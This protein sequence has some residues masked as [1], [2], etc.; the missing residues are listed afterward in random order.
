MVV[1]EKS[2]NVYS[3]IPFTITIDFRTTNLVLKS[4]PIPSHTLPLIQ[5]PIPQYMLELL[6]F[7]ISKLST[8]VH[9]LGNVL[10][11]TNFKRQILS[12]ILFS[13]YETDENAT[14]CGMTL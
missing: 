6:T 5:N 2:I 3:N 1:E 10:R 11:N 8:K 7:K 12:A 14:V 9:F 13:T 4:I